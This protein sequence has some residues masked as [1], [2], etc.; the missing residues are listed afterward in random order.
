[1]V[2]KTIGT[3]DGG[4]PTT[5]QLSNASTVYQLASGLSPGNH[6]VELVKRTEAGMG[7]VKFY[8]FDFGP[9]GRVLQAVHTSQRILGP[10]SPSLLSRGSYC[11]SSNAICY[12]VHSVAAACLLAHALPNSHRTSLRSTPVTFIS[13]PAAPM[14]RCPPD[15]LASGGLA[16]AAREHPTPTGDRRLGQRWLWRRVR[17]RA[18]HR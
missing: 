9:G 2:Q 8:G 3:T 16:A 4:P 7:T 10:R 11:W 15:A 5:I 14:N 18:A 12:L 6:T 13:E 17:Q 1:V